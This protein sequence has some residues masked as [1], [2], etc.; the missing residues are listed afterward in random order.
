MRRIATIA[1]LLYASSAWGQ[2]WRHYGGD[3]GGSH[4]S[5]AAQL[6]RD[7]V[8]Q[9]EVAWVHRSGDLERSA[10]LLKN[11][12][13]Q[14]TPILLPAAAGESLV[15]CTPFSE[16]IALDPGS[17]ERRWS[18]DPQ[19]DTASLRPFRC[20]GVAYY[21]E[22]RVAE[23]ASCRHRIFANT[24]DR[25]LLALDA[26]TGELCRDF[27]NHGEVS[28]FGRDKAADE[29]SNSSPPVVADGLVIN[30]SAVIDFRLAEAPKGIVQAFDSLSGELRWSFD[31]LQ[32]Q[33]G[34]GAANVWAPI[35]VDQSLGLVY[36]PTGTPSPDYYGVNR[37][38]DT[39][40]AN[41]VVALELATGKVRWHFQHVRHD[42]WDY[43]TP[44]QPILFEWQ[45][46]GETVPAL[47]QPTKQGFVFVLDRRSGESLWEITEQPVPSSQI[48]GEKS[49]PTQPKPIAP[50]PLLDPFLMPEQ[51]WG[52]TPWDRGD[53]AR[54]LA[55]LDNLGLFTPLSEK[56]TLMFPGS[57]GGANWGGGAITPGSGVLVLNVNAAPFTGRLVPNEQID[58]S[59]DGKDHP[60]DGQ[61]FVVPMKGTPYTVEIN[62]L[63][64]PLGI[65]CN[66]PPWG[67]LVA[68]DLVA[69]EIL[70]ETALGSVHELGPF[71]LPFHID[72]GTPNL[73]GGIA[74]AGGLF[75]IAATMDRQLRAFD[76]ASGETL[77][78]YT[79]PVDATATPMTYTYRGRQYLV[80]N[81]GGHF[82]FNREAG[83]YLYAFALP[84]NRKAP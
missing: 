68:V 74:T 67:K 22:V 20:R 41:S 60:T 19:V 13:A 42:L 38:D 35:S 15:Y 48:R 36:L 23:D 45:K 83:D 50:P 14:A 49:A 21:E 43:D 71:P 10:E 46:D 63:V 54:Q 76:L 28:Q 55:E 4:Y 75:F 53:C 7:N 39:R 51:A 77:W 30:G 73:G 6:N 81:A 33:A 26:I 8:D 12:S 44:A 82:M 70:W 27:G 29:I 37:P 1:A 18:H 59:Q 34:S 3:A 31:P 78:R 61:R 58:T 16:V 64:S 9:L 66:A 47:A 79:L 57:L 62:A 17:G 32:G 65:P 40:Y 69:G 2:D 24:Y 25:R 52:L 84:D 5:A 56:T 11:S 80:I 72:W